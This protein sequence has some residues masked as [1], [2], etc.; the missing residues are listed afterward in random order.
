MNDHFP[1]TSSRSHTR[2]DT[3]ALQARFA[4][5][6]AGRLTEGAAAL[7]SDV[8]ERLR[9]AREQAVERARAVRKASTAAS[10]DIVAHRGGAA[11][12]A[13]G[14][15]RRSSTPLWTKIASFLP[16]VALIA[17]LLLIQEANTKAQI[18]EA[19]EIDAAL[20]ADDL[21]PGAY[22][23]PGFFEYLKSSRD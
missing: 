8:S 13:A 15:R 11:T 10:E 20:L 3:E 16:L 6:V 23:D 1:P 14:P 4:L 17:G 18:I 12:L 22:S 9:F 2:G 7:P 21:P 5:R 19:A